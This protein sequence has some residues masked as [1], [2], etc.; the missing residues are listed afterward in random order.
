MIDNHGRMQEVSMI[1]LF[2]K[3]PS[4]GGKIAVT[5]CRC[6]NCHLEMR[7]DFVTD[8]SGRLPLSKEQ[9]TFVDVFLRCRG[10][11]SE[12]EKVLGIS[13]PTIRNKLDEIKAALDAKAQV[14][15]PSESREKGATEVTSPSSE[16]RRAVLQRVA[17]GELSA[18]EAL[19]KLEDLPEVN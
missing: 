10:T 11:L 4:C 5:A 6:A 15:P 14:P 8:T 2:E 16:A 17:S 19:Q 7:G 12:V 1:N 3:C 9:L 18:G 13:Y